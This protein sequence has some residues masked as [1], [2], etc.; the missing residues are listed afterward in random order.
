MQQYRPVYHAKDISFEFLEPDDQGNFKSEELH[1]GQN[2]ID[3]VKK[4]INMV[5]QKIQNLEF[6]KGCG[7]EHCDWCNLVKNKYST[8]PAQN[9]GVEAV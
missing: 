9:S 4:Q 8:F 3:T 5:Y 7:D 2:D 1:I 6:E